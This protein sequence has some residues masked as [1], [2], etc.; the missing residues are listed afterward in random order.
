MRSLRTVLTTL[1]IAAITM[2]ATAGCF[3]SDKAAVKAGSLADLAKLKDATFTV[4]SK[5]FTE[6][7]ILCHVTSLALRSVGAT[8]AE[9][10]GLQGSNLTRA[11]LAS[12]SIDMYWEYTGT[13]WMSHNKHDK[14]IPD[15]AEQ[16][17]AVAREDLEKN[18]I[19][20][21]EPAPANN[22]YAIAVKTSTAQEFG[23]A[24]ISDY[25]KLVKTNPAKASLCVASE[26]NGRLTDGLPGLQAA[27]GFTVPPTRLIVVVEDAFYT[28][29]ARGDPCIF[30]EAGTTDGRLKELGLTIL[31]D[32]K[33]FFPIY[34][35]ALTIREPVY[36]SY[37]DLAKI[38]EPLA[39]ALTN[40][41]L[42]QLNGQVDI[43]GEDPSKVAQTWLQDKGF[44][45]K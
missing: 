28:S 13:A 33:H 6:Q 36:K 26:F 12:G 2:T 41:E 38:S 7:L 15:P 24:T 37:P 45:G 30:S 44:I 1:T 3:G 39:K 31:T 11:S 29:A 35:P 20:W 16:Y 34:N 43:K 23:V 32:D 19:W 22:T 25:A 5:E 14:P 17:D 8:I 40:E 42:Q 21:G 18:K 10:C 4:G 27:Y 9:K